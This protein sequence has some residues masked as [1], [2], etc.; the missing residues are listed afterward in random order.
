MGNSREVR[1]FGV[2]AAVRY[3][4]KDYLLSY[5]Y[6]AP[7]LV[8]GL[9]LY[10]AYGVVPNPVMPSYSFTA[11]M[12]FIISAWLAF[13]YIDLEHET[14]QMITSLHMRNL[15][16]YYLCKTIPIGVF[17]GF[18]SIVATL[19]PIL[20]NKFDRFPTKEEIMISFLCHLVLSLLGISAGFLF[21]KKFFPKWYTALGG[22]L[23]FIIIS[24]G[25]QGIIKSLAPAFRFVEWLLP[26]LYR[27][28]V[29]LNNYEDSTAWSIVLGILMPFIYGLLLLGLFLTKMIRRRF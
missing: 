4:G 7:L 21:T 23:G 18:L 15:S 28:M 13:G 11:T 24:I 29:M 12:Q 26:P 5:R 1:G 16:T 2:I 17:T 6:F 27:T 10:L 3:F 14:Q 22:L 20:F 25:S 19:Y 8:Y 9:T